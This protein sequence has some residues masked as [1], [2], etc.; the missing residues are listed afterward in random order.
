[1]S[2]LRSDAT[3]FQLTG[4]LITLRPFTSSNITSEYIGWL[5]NPAVVRYSNQRFRTHNAATCE[6]YLRSFEQTDNMFLAIYKESDFVGTM[7]AYISP[8]HKTADMGILIGYQCWGKG[9]GTDAWTTLM[10][11]LFQGGIRKV[12]GGT[13]R[14]NTAMVNIMLKSGMKADGVRFAQELV[15]GEPEDILY[16]AKFNN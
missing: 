4:Q 13:L 6:A 16:F 14:C 15:N 11:Y 3:H 10:R 5:N 12:T 2:Y 7:T 1:M 9:I 8:P